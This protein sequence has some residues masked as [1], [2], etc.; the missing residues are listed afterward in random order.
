M[1]IFQIKNIFSF[2]K[3]INQCLAVSNRKHSSFYKQKGTFILM[4]IGVLHSHSKVWRSRLWCI[5]RITVRTILRRLTAVGAE[6]C[7]K[8]LGNSKAPPYQLSPALHGPCQDN[9]PAEW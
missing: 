3:K 6:I 8:K 4:R 7:H 1:L 9:K 5:F 2:F